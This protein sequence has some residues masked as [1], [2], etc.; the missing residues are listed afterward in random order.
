M[1][2][3]IPRL[4]EI[5][6]FTKKIRTPVC[7][8]RLKKPHCY[9][10][11]YTETLSRVLPLL[12]L[13]DVVKSMELIFDNDFEKTVVEKDQ[14]AITM[15]LYFNDPPKTASSWIS[16]LVLNKDELRRYSLDPP[17]LAGIIR[18]RMP[19]KIHLVSSEVNCVE[20][21]IRC[22]YFNVKEMVRKGFKEHTNDMERNLA[23]RVTLMMIDQMRLTGHPGIRASCVTEIKVWNPLKVQ[24][25]KQYAISVRGNVLDSISCIPEVD[26]STSISNDINETVELFGIE[27]ANAVIFEQ[28]RNTVSYDGTYVD[29]RHLMMVAD[30]M[31]YRGFVMPISRHGINRTNT[32]PLVRCSFEETADV[33]YDAAMFGEIDDARGVTQNIMTGQVSAIGTGAFDLLVSDWSLPLS[34]N[35]HVDGREKL[36]KTKVNRRTNDI[37]RAPDSIEYLDTNVL[38]RQSRGETLNEMPFVDEVAREELDDAVEQ[39]GNCHYAKVIKNK[40]M[41]ND[42][43]FV[44]S[45]PKMNV[46]VVTFSK[47]RDIKKK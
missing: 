26:W 38:A 33:L 31:T 32:G 15:D 37:D 28:I 41:S 6:D 19:G 10:A 20:W 30:T 8:L 39:D 3:G 13:S 47:T 1:T 27:T 46:Q 17:T 22:R 43:V 35:S 16:R 9:N 44:P 29:P 14:L 45:S 4:K 40:Q 36:I 2:M 18:A 25:E 7:T 23:H 34:V 11:K 21:W 24:N 5:L 42:Y 12:K